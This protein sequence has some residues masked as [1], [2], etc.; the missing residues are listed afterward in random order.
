MFVRFRRQANRFQASLIET[1]RTAGKVR[2]EHVGALGSVDAAASVRERLAFW[3]KLPQRLAALGNRVSDDEHGKIYAALHAHIPM[4]TPDEQRG[5]QEENA[6]DDE[7]FWDVMRDVNAASAEGYK[8][9]IAST[10]TKLKESERS[11][12][13]AA[14]KREAARERPAKLKRGESVAG[15]L[16]KKLDIVTMTKTA[17]FTPRQIRR[18]VLYASLT[19]EEF[20]AMLDRTGG[21]SINAVDRISEREA[22]R[23]I[24]ARNSAP[25]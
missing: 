19:G 7:R 11:A 9:L 14:E 15:G 18:M 5:V 4:V 1:R 21:K 24:R 23:I 2:A 8:G 10:E 20:E 22:R 3:A 25:G 6:S 16:G 13:D 12:A 17:G